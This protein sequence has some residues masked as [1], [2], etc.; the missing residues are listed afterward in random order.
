MSGGVWLLLAAICLLAPRGHGLTARYVEGQ[1]LDATAAVEAI[2]PTVS[3]HQVFTRWRGAPPPVFSVQWGGHVH[4]SRDGAYLFATQADD[5]LRLFI[6][7]RL[8]VNNPGQPL[9]TDREVDGEVAWQEAAGEVRLDRG[10]HA[11]IIQYLHNRGDP[12]VEWT[13][14]RDGAPPVTIPSW[15]LSADST[16]RT[17]VVMPTVLGLWWIAA[18]ATLL[19]TSAA[20]TARWV[21]TG[22]AARALWFAGRVLLFGALAWLYVAGASEHARVVNTSKARADQSG[23]LWD[24]QVVYANR[25]G[26]QPPMLV[27]QRMR[28]PVYAGLLTTIYTPRLSDMAF[29]DLAKRWNIRLSLALLAVLAV[30]F[31]WYLPLLP[32]TLVTLVV[33]FGYFVFR[34]GYTQPELLFYALFFLLFLA[35]C[36]LLVSR[37]RASSVALGVAAGTLA[38]L[39]FLTKALVPP[40]LAL[41]FMVFT[42]QELWRARHRPSGWQMRDLAWRLGAGLAMGLTFLTVVSPYIINSKRAFGSYFYN[43]NTAVYIWYDDG[44]TARGELLPVTDEEGRISRPPETLPS[45]WSYLSTRSPGQIVG[46]I[47][48]GLRDTADRSY[49]TFGYFKYVVLYLAF[50][51]GLAFWY[52]QAFVD[53]VRRHSALVLFLTLYAAIYL[54]ATAFFVPTSSTGAVRFLQ[55]HLAPFFFTLAWF[56][57]RPPFARASRVFHLAVAVVLVVDLAFVWWPRMLTTYAGF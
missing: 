10:S 18:G 50:G 52:R 19:F 37:G 31:A 1:G 34:A 2:D 32:A 6:D 39:A 49:R 7:G 44:A 30:A 55:A 36:R 47:V 24:A 29:F 12:I 40:L 43:V 56:V 38:G 27:G 3:T 42:G 48:E 22:Q 51:L 11:V 33:A 23:Y 45:M 21:A 35:C 26:R 4:V 25:A 16:N 28:M 13:W 15:A 46:R 8:V 17:A 54:P 20:V 57:T 41:F 9:N 14:S 5:P 53:L